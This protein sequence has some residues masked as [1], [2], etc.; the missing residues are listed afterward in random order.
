MDEPSTGP[1]TVVVHL[2]GVGLRGLPGSFLRMATQRRTLRP[3]ARSRI[4]G[5]RF[6]KLVGTGSGQSFSVRDADL[7][8]WG[9]IT[10]WDDESDARVFEQGEVVTHWDRHSFEKARFVL[11][12]IHS[13]G[14][15]AGSDP[16]APGQ[17]PPD[18]STIA[19][20]T[21]ARVRTSTWRNFSTA[22]PPV[23]AAANDSSGLL[24][25]TGIGEAPIGLQGTF[26]IWRDAMSLR[27][28]AQGPAHQ[29]VV[30]R[31]AVTG[32]YSE[33]LFARF[34][35]RSAMGSFCHKSVDLAG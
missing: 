5:L 16:F 8:H 26:S 25:S 32:W 28:F 29:Q 3:A 30:D 19:A 13:R 24:L 35:V 17:K 2:W 7:R 22:V 11:D 34:S 15:W 14:A 18:G 31:T 12:P 1:P 20:I 6:A 33:E 23:A 4:H 9:L 10:V 21:R 27:A